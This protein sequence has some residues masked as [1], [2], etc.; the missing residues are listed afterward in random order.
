MRTDPMSAVVASRFA[1]NSF[2]IIVFGHALRNATG[3]RWPGDL[4]SLL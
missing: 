4:K 2:E 3:W 1:S